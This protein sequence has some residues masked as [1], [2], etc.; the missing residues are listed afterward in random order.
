MLEH[1]K[2][3]FMKNITKE[4]VCPRTRF[5][6]VVVE[7]YAI[8]LKK[9]KTDQKNSWSTIKCRV[10]RFNYLDPKQIHCWNYI[11]GTLTHISVWFKREL[12]INNVLV[13]LTYPINRCCMITWHSTSG[14]NACMGTFYIPSKLIRYALCIILHSIMCADSFKNYAS[15]DVKPMLLGFLDRMLEM[16]R[17]LA[18]TPW[19]QC[20]WP[21][22]VCLYRGQHLGGILFHLE[23]SFKP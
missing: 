18:L 5:V 21:L 7:N 1:G 9:K 16:Y 17:M 11:H 15:E 14:Y 22:C 3:S 10:A 19:T 20:Y 6:K 4:Q 13:R 2:K 12:F 8:R 23:V